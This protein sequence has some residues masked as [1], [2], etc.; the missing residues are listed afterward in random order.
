MFGR[1]KFYRQN[2]A[3]STLTL[4]DRGR[5]NSIHVKVCQDHKT[6]FQIGISCPET[7]KNRVRAKNWWST[8]RKR[9]FLVLVGRVHETR[10]R[11]GDRSGKQCTE[12]CRNFDDRRTRCSWRRLS[13]G[14]GERDNRRTRALYGRRVK[15]KRRRD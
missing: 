10:T 11:G 14:G 3:C 15:T 6:R 9:N 4:F 1:E 5:G 7:S 2:R 12:K 13:A 8:T